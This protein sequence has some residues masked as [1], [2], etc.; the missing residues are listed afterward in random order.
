MQ[1]AKHRN[2]EIAS[3]RRDSH[4]EADF[5]VGRD[6]A[7]EQERETALPTSSGL[8]ELTALGR[9]C[10]TCCTARSNPMVRC[11]SPTEQEASAQRARHSPQ[12]A[13][14]LFRL[15]HI[16]RYGRPVPAARSG[17]E[18]DFRIVQ[19]HVE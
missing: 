15:A 6:V 10:S 8:G 12:T 2:A 14:P 11:R 19:Q 3:A 9:P 1:S 5:V 17:G 16:L 7:P 4:V 13:D 18:A